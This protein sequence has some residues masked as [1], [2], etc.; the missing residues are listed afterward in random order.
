MIQALISACVDTSVHSGLLQMHEQ[1]GSWARLAA[2][3]AGIGDAEVD[4]T[5]MWR[6]KPTSRRRD[7]A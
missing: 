4:H 6:L 2:R 1:E 7:G 5:W 3:L